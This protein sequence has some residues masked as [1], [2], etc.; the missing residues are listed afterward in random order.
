M[1][2]EKQYDLKQF[3]DHH[4]VS[5]PK[6]KSVAIFNYNFEIQ[7]SNFT[8]LRNQKQYFL[9]SQCKNKDKN[10]FVI[11]ESGND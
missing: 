2:V 5:Q 11:L 1:K 7:K 6:Q 3:S 8:N 4:K 10:V 9:I